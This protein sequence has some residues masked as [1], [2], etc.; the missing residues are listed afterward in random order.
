MSLFEYQMRST[1]TCAKCQAKQYNFEPYRQVGIVAPQELVE[2][3]NHLS[4]KNH[5]K[6]TNHWTIRTI[7]TISST[8]TIEPSEPSKTI[9]ARKSHYSWRSCI[10]TK[11]RAWWLMG[12]MR[13]S[14]PTSGTWRIAS[15]ARPSCRIIRYDRYFEPDGSFKTIWTRWFKLI[16]P[17]FQSVIISLNHTSIGDA[18]S[19]SVDIASLGSGRHLYAV[20]VC[21]T[22]AS[23]R[24]LINFILNLINIFRYHQMQL[25]PVKPVV[26]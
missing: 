24:K 19:D 16:I 14:P 13:M 7:W 6:H 22:F 3:L 11:G 1:I 12:W 25:F 10:G 5:H 9:A 20:E 17:Y 4:H 8:W 21:A 15:A 26:W 2:P 23:M 18:Y